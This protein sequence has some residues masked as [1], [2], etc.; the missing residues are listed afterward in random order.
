MALATMVEGSLPAGHGIMM[1]I[2]FF[3]QSAAAEGPAR[4][5]QKTA[6]NTEKAKIRLGI[7]AS[8]IRLI[9]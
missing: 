5:R 4:K 1:I 2:G 9:F 8:F 6:A 7:R 3:G